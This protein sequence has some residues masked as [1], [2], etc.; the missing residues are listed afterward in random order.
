[1]TAKGTLSTASVQDR[2]ADMW[3]TSTV[4]LDIP[5]GSSTAFT[6]LTD[7]CVPKD[8]DTW[9]QSTQGASSLRDVIGVLW[10]ESKRRYNQGEV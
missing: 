5:A 4:A 6:H 9:T 3:N 8:P 2:K 7:R 1:M 10:Q